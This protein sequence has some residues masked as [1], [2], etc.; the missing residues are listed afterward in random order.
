ML[1]DT[2]QLLENNGWLAQ[3][4]YIYIEEEVK[5]QTYTL[6]IHWTLHREK[7]AG[8]VAYRLYIRSLSA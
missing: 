7:I 4:C 8:Q 2:V 1:S 5:A 6:P 3:D